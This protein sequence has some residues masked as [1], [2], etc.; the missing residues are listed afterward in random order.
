[1]PRRTRR[2]I[3]FGT[4]VAYPLLYVGYALLSRSGALPA[5]S[6]LWAPVAVLL[7]FGFAIGLF[8]IY[9]VTR[10]RA[11]PDDTELDERQRGLAV[12]ARALSYGVLLAFIVAIAAA[13]AVYVT[14]VGPVTLGADLL[15][16]VAIVVGVYLPVLP[17][18]VLAW[19]EPDAPPEDV[20]G[21]NGSASRVGGAAR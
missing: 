3:V 10:N 15:L 4:F 9:G 1:M 20:A 8:V 21:T 17:S 11:E 5:V 12:R 14:S 16:P 6:L 19:I 2:L 18:A 13:W 7:M